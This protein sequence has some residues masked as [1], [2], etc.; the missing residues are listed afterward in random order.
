MLIVESERL[1]SRKCRYHGAQ[2]LLLDADVCECRP[3]SALQRTADL[4]CLPCGPGAPTCFKV[5]KYD[6]QTNVILT[7][8]FGSKLVASGHNAAVSSRTSR[9]ALNSLTLKNSKWKWRQNGSSSKERSV[10]SFSES[11]IT[12]YIHIDT[13]QWPP[14]SH[15]NKLLVVNSEL[16]NWSFLFVF[17]KSNISLSKIWMHF[18]QIYVIHKYITNKLYSCSFYSSSSW[19]IPPHFV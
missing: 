4:F 8:G 2:C 11:Y 9:P 3:E 1:M 12:S 19:V 17:F 16:Q 5:K 15:Y 10:F 14:E 18:S 13:S 7:A 6:F